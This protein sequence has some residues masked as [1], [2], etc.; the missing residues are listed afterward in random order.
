MRRSAAAPRG[1]TSCSPSKFLKQFP[2]RSAVV[3]GL[4]AQHK[5]DPTRQL[6]GIMELASLY[7]PA[8][9]ER[10]LSIAAECNTYSHTFV[11][12]VLEHRT[13]PV[14]DGTAHCR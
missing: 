13:A 8:S 2:Q 12:G 1:R 6:H 11:R 7:D 14:V 5:L 4:L 10:T 9:L 3:E